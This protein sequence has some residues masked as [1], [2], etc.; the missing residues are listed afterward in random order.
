MTAADPRNW[1]WAEACAMLAR[2]ERLHVQVFQPGAD[3]VQAAN[4]EPPIDVFETEQRL[5]II[6]ALPGVEPQELD[7]SMTMDGLLVS[8]VRRLPATARNASIRRL[9]I[10]H[11]RFERLVK[12]PAAGLDLE[13]WEFDRGCLH[14]SLVKRRW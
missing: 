12:L 10:P 8:G 1:M 7:I 9:E 13:Q 5:W 6:V 11:G 14:L 3:R 4:W 2:A